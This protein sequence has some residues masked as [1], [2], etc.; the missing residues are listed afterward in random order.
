MSGKGACLIAL[1]G[2]I[3]RANLS[4]WFKRLVASDFIRKVGE[5]FATRIFLIGIG[6]VTTVIV[7]RTLGPE[8]RGFYA[9]AMAV[10]AIG[11][12]FGNL[13]LHASNTY[14][15]AR[16]PELLPKLV[17]NSLMVS[18]LLG[19]CGS[20]VTWVV[21][22]IWP[23]LAPVKGWL[24][25]LSLAW[26]P[27]GLAYMLLQNLLLG[28]HEIRAYNK[29]EVLNKLVT[30]VLI[31][32]VLAMR[33]VTVE[34]V[35][36]AGFLAVIYSFVWVLW[37]LSP[38]MKQAPYPSFS[39]FTE[40]LRYGLRAYAA[41]FFAFLVLR[42]DL[43]MVKH[44][45]GSAQ[46]GYYSVAVNMADMVSMLAV[47]CGTIIFPKLSA[48]ECVQEKLKFTVNTALLIGVVMVVTSLAAALLAKPL[49]LMLFGKTFLPMLNAFLLL[50]PAIVL[51]SV[52]VVF[53]NFF[54]AIGMPL[55]TVYSPGIASFVNIGLN[56]LLI[57]Q[58]GIE[59]ASIS[60]IFAYGLMLIFSIHHMHAVKVNGV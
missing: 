40:N 37:R 24:L 3:S 26:V 11:V 28:I 15:V 45:L 2:G 43:L 21:F 59:G 13:G 4:S 49:I 16:N 42:I 44:L 31:V 34:L 38:H 22:Y 9:V 27:F 10:G 46:A 8:G 5:T 35:F 12:Q 6:L 19:G 39:L 52:N 41:A 7:T 51:L 32:V 30:V 1:Q 57:P 48:M 25:I 17:G 50:L 56:A 20:L 53:M 54:A 55:V 18:F 58:Y 29:V 33:Y 14:H 60:S 23:Q 47:V 36:S